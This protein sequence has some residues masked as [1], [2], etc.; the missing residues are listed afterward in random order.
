LEIRRRNDLVY[1]RSGGSMKA[2][3]YTGQ[4]FDRLICI[5]RFTK[6][7]PVTTC[8]DALVGTRRLSRT[9]TSKAVMSTVEDAIRKR[10]FTSANSLLRLSTS[11]ARSDATRGTRRFGVKLSN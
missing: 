4:T 8:A 10:F 6:N 11:I 9:S 1:Y 7:G 3:D 2:I 5:S